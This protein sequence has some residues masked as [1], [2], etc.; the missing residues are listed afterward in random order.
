[1]NCGK[2]SS[3]AFPD[4]SS[5]APGT[6]KIT[7]GLALLLPEVGEQLP[8]LRAPPWG[9]GRGTAGPPRPA[10]ETCRSSG[11]AGG[12]GAGGQQG[13]QRLRWLGHG[14][15][16]EQPASEDPE[17]THWTQSAGLC[18]CSGASPTSHMG[19]LGM[20]NLSVAV[21]VDVGAGPTLIPQEAGGPAAGPETA[22]PGATL[23][24]GPG[25]SPKP[26]PR[27]S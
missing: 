27:N 14:L 4:R 13:G 9:E 17:G 18:G 21:A 11:R 15:C 8:W 19:E 20:G 12:R 24:S 26:A 1:M 23:G 10:R 16:G 22:V 25:R 5:V 7:D 2:V 6:F 3:P